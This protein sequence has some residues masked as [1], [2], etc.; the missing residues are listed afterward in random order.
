MK[1]KAFMKF[2]KA[3]ALSKN[4]VNLC[5]NQNL[6]KLKVRKNQKFKVKK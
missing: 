5:C 1:N 4:Q 3:L 2:R 6:R